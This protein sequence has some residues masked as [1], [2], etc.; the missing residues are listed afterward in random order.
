VV[1]LLSVLIVERG[2]DI[3]SSLI[4]KFLQKWQN[5]CKYSVNP[6]GVLNSCEIEIDKNSNKKLK[7]LNLISGH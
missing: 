2:Q 7:K 4:A 6:V 1:I 5:N 3:I